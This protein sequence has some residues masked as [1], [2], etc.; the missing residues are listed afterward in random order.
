MHPAL[1]V[2]LFTTASGAGYGML[3]WLGLLAPLGLLPDGRRL[4]RHRIAARPGA[5]DLRADVVDAAPRPP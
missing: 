5:G 1:S 2:I 4:R 3:F